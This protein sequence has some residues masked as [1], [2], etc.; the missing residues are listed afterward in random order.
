MFGLPS[1]AYVYALPKVPLVRA[2][3]MQSWRLDHHFPPIRLQLHWVYSV[4]AYGITLIGFVSL[5]R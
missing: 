3:C 1:L 4:L 2:L 5:A